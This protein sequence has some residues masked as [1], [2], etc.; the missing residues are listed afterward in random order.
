MKKQSNH[1]IR[2]SRVNAL[3]KGRITK[4]LPILLGLL[5][6]ETQ[7]ELINELID[8]IVI[9]GNAALPYI[10]RSIEEHGVE[11]SSFLIKN[12]MILAR[13]KSVKAVKFLIQIYGY[14]NDFYIHFYISS[15]IGRRLDSTH[16]EDDLLLLQK[17]EIPAVLYELTKDKESWYAFSFKETDHPFLYLDQKLRNDI[18]RGIKRC[19]EQ[20]DWEKGSWNYLFNRSFEKYQLKKVS[21]K[22]LLPVIIGYV[23]GN[24]SFR[25]GGLIDFCFRDLGFI[26]ER[27]IWEYN[28][29]LIRE[30]PS[31]TVG[32]LLRRKANLSQLNKQK[33]GLEKPFSKLLYALLFLVFFGFNLAGFSDLLKFSFKKNLFV[34]N[35]YAWTYSPEELDRQIKN[36]NN[37]EK[38]KQRIDSFSDVKNTLFSQSINYEDTLKVKDF[39]AFADTTFLDLSKFLQLNTDPILLGDIRELEDNIQTVNSLKKNINILDSLNFDFYALYE[40]KEKLR[41]L[42]ENLEVLHNQLY[43]KIS[44]FR[45]SIFEENIDLNFFDLSWSDSLFFELSIEEIRTRDSLNGIFDSLN[46]IIEDSFILKVLEDFPEH[47]LNSSMPLVQGVDYSF[48]GEPSDSAIVNNIV[49]VSDQPHITSPADWYDLKIEYFKSRASKGEDI[50]LILQVLKEIKQ[51]EQEVKSQIIREDRYSYNFII[52]SSYMWDFV[53]LNLDEEYFTF[54]FSLFDTMDIYI[55]KIVGYH[56]LYIN[57]ADTVSY[58]IPLFRKDQ[59]IAFDLSRPYEF[60]YPELLFEAYRNTNS[61]L[62]FNIT[63]LNRFELILWIIFML[64]VTGLTSLFVF[65][66]RKFKKKLTFR[67]LCQNALFAVP[68]F[69]TII[70][71]QRKGNLWGK[72][73]LFSLAFFMFSIL[74]LIPVQYFFKEMINWAYWGVPLFIYCGFVLFNFWYLKEIVLKENPVYNL[75]MLH[76][77]GKDIIKNQ[78]L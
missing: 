66:F 26:K 42:N 72:C 8:A 16:I 25:R 39:L 18:S 14:T 28:L 58:N 23:K 45:D 2:I 49:S 73:L 74:I 43:D 36:Y 22:I 57:T 75:L 10:N 40:K 33:N 20:T 5:H 65:V 64:F 1:M 77:S 7:K 47:I 37:I 48:W 24:L 9:F 3:K 68:T 29:N 6:K 17:H 19:H 38:Y 44:K 76:S 78:S 35:A 46:L 13:I 67:E 69:L 53:P 27:S 61:F 34:N 41:D 31:L 15:I 4:S 32:Q 55:E 50:D 62:F 51:F 11:D 70:S 63:F 59:Y 56:D 54:S 60:E 71:C 12:I 30:N 21:L 52:S